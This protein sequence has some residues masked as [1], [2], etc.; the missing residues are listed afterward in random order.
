L[1][2]LSG[3]P[4]LAWLGRGA[5]L[6]AESMMMV[7]IGCTLTLMFAGAPGLKDGTR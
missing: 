1:P 2:M 4:P 6:L 5:L 3:R 7:S